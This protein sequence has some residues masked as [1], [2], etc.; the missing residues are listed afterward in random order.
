MRMIQ[1]SIQL[2]AKEAAGVTHGS[3]TSLLRGT[4]CR[5]EDNVAASGQVDL[6]GLPSQTSTGSRKAGRRMVEAEWIR[7][8]RS[9]I[10]RIGCDPG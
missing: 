8:V 6:F 5:S 10:C 4:V 9:F 1:G 2:P 7:I 3:R